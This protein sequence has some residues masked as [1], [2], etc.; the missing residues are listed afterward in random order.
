[1]PRQPA[2]FGCSISE[3]L[4]KSAAETLVSSGLRDLGYT[5]PCPLSLY[6]LPAACADARA[7]P[8]IVLRSDVLID[9]C[10][11][12]PSRTPDGKPHYDEERFP[13]G[14][15]NLTDHL[16]GLGLLVRAR[17]PAHAGSR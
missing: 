1:M 4:I 17:A 7:L 6:P 10:W 13:S 15:R 11:Q 2:S 3:A 12:A 8:P 16:H 14:L 5:C 9:D